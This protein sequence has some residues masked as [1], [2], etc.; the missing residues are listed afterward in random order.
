MILELFKSR[1]KEEKRI[2]N[3]YSSLLPTPHE[4]EDI[5][6]DAVVRFLEAPP[7]IPHG[8]MP[9]NYFRSL[10]KFA[11]ADHLRMLKGQ[12]ARESKLKINTGHLTAQT[13]I[14]GSLEY[15]VADIA[16]LICKYNTKKN[17]INLLMSLLIDGKSVQ[18]LAKKKLAS[19]SK[20]Y[21]LLNSF[22]DDVMRNGDLH[23]LAIRNL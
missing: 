3:V 1:A 16:N 2:H 9:V 7:Y 15:N 20:I 14:D 22:Q 10:L 23:D 6:M 8:E 19:K 12:K 13:D 17:D 11:A 21:R 4:A 5:Y 18:S